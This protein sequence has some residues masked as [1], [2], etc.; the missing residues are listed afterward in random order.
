V[1]AM[2]TARLMLDGMGIWPGRMETFHTLEEQTMG[3]WEGKPRQL[4]YTEELVAHLDEHAWTFRA[5]GGGESQED[6]AARLLAWLEE[7]ARPSG[8]ERIALV[9]HGMV[10]RSALVSLLGLD[11]RG[12]VKIHVE[13]TSITRLE[14]VEGGWRVLSRNDVAHLEAAGMKRLTGAATPTQVHAVSVGEEEV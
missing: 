4:V 3:E 9:T 10:I 5:P 7:V 8:C 2:Q 1:R 11:H 14:P 12:V 6:C 13:N